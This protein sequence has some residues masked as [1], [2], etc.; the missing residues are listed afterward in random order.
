MVQ[1]ILHC[2][3]DI[4]DPNLPF[5]LSGSTIFLI[6]AKGCDLTGILKNFHLPLLAATTANTLVI[7][8]Q[9][10]VYAKQTGM[11]SAFCCLVAHTSLIALHRNLLIYYLNDSV[12]PFIKS[13]SKGEIEGKT[14]HQKQFNR[15]RPELQ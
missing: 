10:L 2:L 13:L 14:E 7:S 3:W 8:I 12:Q 5:N 6:L 9:E 15:Q 1:Q 4:W 11:I